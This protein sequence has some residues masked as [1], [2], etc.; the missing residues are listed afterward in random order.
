M[1]G[2]VIGENSIV[3]ACAFVK[4]ETIFAQNSLIVG[5]PAKVLRT[6]SEQEIT[7]KSNGTKD[8]QRLVTRCLN[9]FK[10]IEPLTEVEANRPVLQ[11]EN[12]IPKSQL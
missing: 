1:D 5:T 7:W 4:A 12:I 8:Y 6:L 10:E 2:A 11:F 9:T 3:G